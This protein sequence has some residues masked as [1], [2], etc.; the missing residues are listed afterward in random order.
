MENNCIGKMTVEECVKNDIRSAAVVTVL[1]YEIF[2]MSLS[3]FSTTL[4]KHQHIFFSTLPEQGQGKKSTGASFVCRACLKMC[5]FPVS[6]FDPIRTEQTKKLLD[7]SKDSFCDCVLTNLMCCNR[8]ESD[9]FL[10][11]GAFYL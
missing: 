4:R 10:G 5:H 2:I 7:V 3:A 1:C 9:Q 11:N 8:E 6:V